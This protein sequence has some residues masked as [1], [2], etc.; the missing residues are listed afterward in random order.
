MCKHGWI[1]FPIQSA[2]LKPGRLRI[3][4]SKS[5]HGLV[6]RC[7]YWVP[8]SRIPLLL[9]WRY[10]YWCQGH[11]ADSVPTSL[12]ESPLQLPHDRV[13]S[14]DGPWAF[15]DYQINSTALLR[16]LSTGRKFELN[17][18]A[19]MSLVDMTTRSRRCKRE[20]LQTQTPSRGVPVVRRKDNIS[21]VTPNLSHL[22]SSI[23]PANP[24]P[25][26]QIFFSTASIWK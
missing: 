16:W 15:K 22:P 2:L 12:S 21:I 1:I 17:D 18:F 9:Q 23:S 13:W 25:F 4:Q 8:W 11:T 3:S 5:V 20:C 24:P 19:K 14:V 6:H 7:R 10:A 26:A